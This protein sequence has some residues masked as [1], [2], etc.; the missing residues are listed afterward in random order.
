MDEE[1][2]EAALMHDVLE[3]TPVTMSQVVKA[4]GPK[5]AE[6]VDGVTKLTQID[7]QTKAEEQAESFRKM[8]LAVIE[9]IRVIIIKMADR[10]HNMKSVVA[11]HK[12]L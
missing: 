3:D 1:S 10:L 4:F 9:D 7:A 8:M 6:L 12:K 5:V 11:K 2:L